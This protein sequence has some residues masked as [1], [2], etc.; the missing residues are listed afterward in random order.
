MT[1]HE[2]VELLVINS[3]MNY[4]HRGLIKVCE[5][6]AGILYS[7][8][9]THEVKEANGGWCEADTF[10]CIT[11]VSNYIQRDHDDCVELACDRS[12]EIVF[13]YRAKSVGAIIRK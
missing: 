5:S 1:C 3:R 11:T 13:L 6:E 7:H 8:L 4:S 12:G 10:L 2:F 9:E